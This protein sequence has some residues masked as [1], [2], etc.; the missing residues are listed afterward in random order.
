MM[1]L[2]KFDL[3]TSYKKWS[4]IS[5]YKFGASIYWIIKETSMIKEI[6]RRLLDHSMSTC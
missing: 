5:Q 6:K 2:I 4:N 1:D 3:S